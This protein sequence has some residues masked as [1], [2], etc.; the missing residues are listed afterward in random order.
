MTF[1]QI[2]RSSFVGLCIVGSGLIGLACASGNG[3]SRN[4]SG[5]VVD[6]GEINVF[7]IRAGDCLDQL[8]SGEEI[9]S[10][11]VVP[12][13]QPHVYEVYADFDIPGF[14]GALYPN[15]LAAVDPALP[16]MAQIADEGCLDRFSG[17]VGTSYDLSEFYF[18]SLTPT[19][20][21]WDEADD[22]TVLCLLTNE[23]ETAMTGTARNSGR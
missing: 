1:G 12:C 10:A 9:G 22:R 17:F 19:S 6:S 5:Q 8:A 13:G 7:E 11:D 21:S 4:E 20:T 14:P 2:R 16:S 18:N 23:F 15:I 3:V